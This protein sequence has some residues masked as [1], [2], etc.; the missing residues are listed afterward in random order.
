MKPFRDG[1]GYIV[2]IWLVVVVIIGAV[3]AVGYARNSSDVRQTMIS[4]AERLIAVIDVSATSGIH[5]LDAVEEQTAR[6]LLDNARIIADMTTMSIPSRDELA[7]IAENN[8]LH[9]VNI[10]DRD[11]RSLVRV[12]E[13]Q[14]HPD[15]LG[16]HRPEVESVLRGESFEA[17]VGF[18][19][20]RYSDD[21]RY[22]VV[23]ARPDGGAVVL[24]TDSSEMLAF[25]QSVGLGTLFRKLGS[26]EGIT[27][28]VLQ[29]RDGIIAA[30]PGVM[31][32]VR[33]SEDPF[34]TIAATGGRHVRIL[35]GTDGDVL[36]VVRP[37]VVDDVDLGLLR[38]G[39]STALLKAIHTRA[40]RQFVMLFLAAVVSGAFVTFFLMLRQNYRIL[41]TEHDRILGEVRLMEEETRRSEWL[42]SMG[43][44]AAGVAHEIRNPL[45]AINIISQRLKTEFTPE[46]D[47][48][49]YRGMLDTV[50]T[51]IRRI[52]TII[53][54]FL[55]YA[56]PPK[57]SIS[58][59]L[60]ADIVTQ[61]VAVVA[62]KARANAIEITVECPSGLICR[63]DGDQMKQV[64]LNILLNAIDAIGESGRISVACSK[65]V[66]GVML[67]IADSGPGFAD[68]VLSKIFDPYFTTHDHG[69]GLGLSE[70]YR[71]VTSH[72]GT[73]KAAN[74]PSGGAIITLLI[75]DR[76]E[77]A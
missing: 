62:E 74:A 75:P 29:D 43:R 3:L 70:V 22:G 52:S 2:L 26:L 5:A 19:D 57:L 44:L 20:G 21:I 13:D 11:G 66:D 49:E 60:L 37:L 17:I 56:R 73:V 25:S 31:E 50:G 15:S 18:I 51:E 7:S 76:G 9:M 33:I 8:A 14:P 77:D 48:D 6:R 58:R 64:L 34:L 28:I 23:V 72:D 10:L 4:E 35:P 53:E 16:T 27:Y 38:I 12:G 59:V 68:D 24:N 32:M 69:T 30:S 39:L 36:E 55:T 65:R 47:T 42:V 67:E 54:N 61:V 1:T 71:I 63:C 40:T 45:N 46:K 41:A